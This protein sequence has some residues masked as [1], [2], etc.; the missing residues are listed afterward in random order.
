METVR[1]KA[2]Q[3]KYYLTGTN[4]LTYDGRLVNVCL[5]YTSL[6][7]LPLDDNY[8]FCHSERSEESCEKTNISPGMMLYMAIKR[9]GIRQARQRRNELITQDSLYCCFNTILRLKYML[10]LKKL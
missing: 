2:S 3:A 4:A 9:R 10:S 1:K 7:K 6:W 8:L 5:L